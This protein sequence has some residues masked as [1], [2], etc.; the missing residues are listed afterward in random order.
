MKLKFFNKSFYF[1]ADEQ[2][3]NKAIGMIEQY[4]LKPGVLFT[5][6][7]LV[8]YFT[9]QIVAKINKHEKLLNVLRKMSPWMYLF[10]ILGIT[11]FNRMPGE[12]EIRL[13]HDVWFTPTGFHESNVLGFAFNTCLYIPLGYL[14]YKFLNFPKKWLVTIG[15]VF[16][17][18]ILIESMQYIFA[19]GVTAI[20][21]LVANTM[22][23][24]LGL[25][26]AITF[27]KIKEKKHI[28]E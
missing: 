13:Y 2:Q 18:S 17:S 10:I 7:L 19:R 16:F 14:L 24:L 8:A 6:V 22:G 11:F 3:I 4:I 26:F 1:L 20:D 12:R 23:G 25:I 9:F 28:L 21:D 27:S 15:I 5:L